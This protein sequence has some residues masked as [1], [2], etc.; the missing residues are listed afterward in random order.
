MTLDKM[1][2][3]KIE[4]QVL[5]QKHQMRKHQLVV[6][7]EL[8]SKKMLT[9]ERALLLHLLFSKGFSPQGSLLH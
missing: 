3:F 7:F 6:V 9:S 4:K 1:E 2:F 5:I 8:F